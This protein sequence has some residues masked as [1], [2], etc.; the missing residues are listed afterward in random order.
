MSLLWKIWLVITLLALLLTAIGCITVE[1]P[2]V[3]ATVAAELT[4]VAQEATLQP[5]VSDIPSAAPT[6]TPQPEPTAVPVDTPAPTTAPTFTPL[7]RPRQT[8]TSTPRPTATPTVADLISRLRPSLARI[9]TTSGSGSGF[10][11][12][13]SGLVATNAHVV[14]CCRNVTVIL[15]SSRYQGTVLGR[16]DRM[17]LA[18]VRLN[19]GGNFTPAPFGSAGWV[20]VGDDV[21]ALGFPLSSDL[22]SELTVTRGIVSSERKIDGYD[23]L[24]T[25]AALNPGNSGGPLVNRDGEV[26][27]MNTSKHSAAEGVG[28]ALSVGEMDDRLS[29]LEIPASVSTVRPRP[30][31]TRRAASRSE[32]ATSTE[33]FLQVSAGDGYTCGLTNERNI[34]C[35]GQPNYDQGQANPPSGSFQQVSV[36]AWHTCGLSVSGHVVCW[37][38]GLHGKTTPS[39][40]TFQQISLGMHHACGLKTDSSVDCWGAD[41]NGSIKPPAG[42]FQQV[43]AG[44]RYS[45]GVK[46]DGSIVCWGRNPDFEQSPTPPKGTF[47]QISTGLWTCGV[48]TDGV[49]VCQNH[50]PGLDHYGVHTAPRGKFQQVSVGRLH[51]CG[52]K[53]DGEVVC[54]GYGGGASLPPAGSFQQISAGWG[55]NCGVKTDGS[56]VCWGDNEYGQ[57]TP[58]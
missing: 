39:M 48:K 34:V 52:L 15:G 11:Y 37:G 3:P 4:R 36:G 19:S 42:T 56:V 45:C 1:Q 18:V 31:A 50:N 26:I 57:A 41:V 28:F 38:S 49:I 17:D 9:I 7:P 5:T 6:D 44:N 14:D 33:T 13:R 8:A 35:W 53:T 40:E 30:T 32:S 10:V 43:S 46:T 27:G 24:Q 58:P 25:D 22:G 47:Q 2:D 16:D 23:Y 55:H 54:W 29:T 51:A 20:S 21:M 12:D